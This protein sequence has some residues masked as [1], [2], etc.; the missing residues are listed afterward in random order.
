[1]HVSWPHLSLP[2]GKKAGNT[3]NAQMSRSECYCVLQYVV[4]AFLKLA[5]V[6]SSDTLIDV[7]CNDGELLRAALVL[8]AL[9]NQAP[10]CAL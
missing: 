5:E 8:L 3:S 6:T 10:P 9:H 7:G 1:M 2:T 4:E